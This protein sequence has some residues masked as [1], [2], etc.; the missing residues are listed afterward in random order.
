[1]Q[2]YRIVG[3]DEA[4]PKAGSISYVSP[5]ARV[6]ISGQRRRRGRCRR[7]GAGDH[8]D[9][10][11]GAFN[12]IDSRPL[13]ASLVGPFVPRHAGMALHHETVIIVD[14]DSAASIASTSASAMPRLLS[15]LLAVIFLKP[16]LRQ[17]G[18]Q[19]LQP[20]TTWIESR[21]DRHLRLRCM[22]AGPLRCLQNGG[23][24]HRIVGGAGCAAA[25]G[26][27]LDAVAIDGEAPAAITRAGLAAAIREDLARIPGRAAQGVGIIGH[28]GGETSERSAEGTAYPKR[29]V[30]LP[31]SVSARDRPDYFCRRDRLRIKQHRLL[32]LLA[33]Q[34]DSLSR[35]AIFTLG[36]MSGLPSSSPCICSQPSLVT[37]WRVAVRFHASVTCIPRLWPSPVDGAH[38]RAGRP[39]HVRGC[40]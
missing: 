24:L 18:R 14:R 23:R 29:P 11:S 22:D 20:F 35:A 7:S 40:R 15:R 4:D 26:C 8:R 10:V 39:R 6:L 33:V 3:E 37:I 25:S 27:D 19:S 13:S 32:R 34:T 21:P 17:I 9:R 30:C 16:L 38:D 1:M 36:S 12:A 2:I 31:A 5:V 28:V